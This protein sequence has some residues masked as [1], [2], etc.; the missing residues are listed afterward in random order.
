MGPEI[1]QTGSP[2]T[3]LW[4]ISIALLV[5]TWVLAALMTLA[6]AVTIPY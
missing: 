6:A 5:I 3:Y 4:L 1:F 2:W